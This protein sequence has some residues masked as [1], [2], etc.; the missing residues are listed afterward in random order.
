MKLANFLS[1]M[2]LVPLAVNTLYAA[3]KT[4]CG[5]DDRVPHQDQ[6]I[7][8]LV[9]DL[10]ENKACTA[11]LISKR[12]AISAGHCAQFYGFLEFDVPE[13]NLDGRFNHP[14]LTKIYPVD[15]TVDYEDQGL[16]DDW[17]IIRLH[18]N[19]LTG[20]YPGEERGFYQI[21]FE[22][23]KLNQ[24]ITIAGYGKDDQI[25]KSYT[26][27]QSQGQLFSVESSSI[28]RHNADT[29][30]GNSGS[31]II[32]ADTQRIIGIHTN[33]GCHKSS[34]GGTWIKKRDRLLQ[35]IRECQSL[36]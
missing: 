30:S 13:T 8:R 17:M 33:G 11:T 1:L 15:N 21:D 32:N 36:D 9:K 10:Q 27:Q 31:A 18:A 23:L 14:D 4:L 3:Q 24:K 25:A 26:L 22:E 19:A 35:A 29:T 12:C 34:N 28:L 2:I 16:G 7:G 6:K 5:A 20:L